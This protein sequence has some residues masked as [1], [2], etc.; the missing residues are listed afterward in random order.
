VYRHYATPWEILRKL[1]QA[2]PAGHSYLKPEFT[3]Q[4]LDQFVK[5]HSDTES[6]RSMQA[7]KQKLFLGFRQERQSA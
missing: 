2:L 7:A 3:L 4:A 5:T 6:A 1:S